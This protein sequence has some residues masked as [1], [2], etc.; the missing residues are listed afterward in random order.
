MEPIHLYGVSSEG[1]STSSFR[2]SSTTLAPGTA[3]AR[4]R[5]GAGARNED[6]YHP[7]MSECRQALP[8]AEHL[9]EAEPGPSLAASAGLQVRPSSAAGAQVRLAAKELVEETE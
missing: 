8:V 3:A 6:G 4:R 2:Q 9:A 7:F 1:A 5:H